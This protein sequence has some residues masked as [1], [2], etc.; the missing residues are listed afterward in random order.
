MSGSSEL[1][2][3]VRH[4]PSTLYAA[5]DLPVGDKAT[6]WAIVNNYNHY[7]DLH[8]QVRA[9]WSARSG[10]PGKAPYLEAS[11]TS[12]TNV[13]TV[14]PFPL[15]MRP[16]GSSYRVRIR[17][18]ANVDNV[19]SPGRVAVILSTPF[20][21]TAAPG[22]VLAGAVSGRI[23]TDRVWY[24]DTQFTNTTAAFITGKS[25][26]ARAWDNM[27]ALNSSEAPEFFTNTNTPIDV[28]GRDSG[29][30]QCLVCCMVYLKA[31][32]NNTRLQY[33]EATEWYG[34]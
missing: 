15:A 6:R 23:P 20:A 31:G 25:K 26:G 7:A 13:L 9:H 3:R 30:A 16:D 2:Y 27:I 14:G 24:T 29:V 18:G 8:G 22:D 10:G 34:E 32:G 19:L 4:T 17:V 12:W 33:F 11:S 21:P 28:G 1:K 5:D